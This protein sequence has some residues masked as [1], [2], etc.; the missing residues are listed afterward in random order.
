MKAKIY[1]ISY[2][3]FVGVVSLAVSVFLDQYYFG[4]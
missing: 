3:F 2:F 4:K 1:Y